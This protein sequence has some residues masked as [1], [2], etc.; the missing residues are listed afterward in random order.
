[1]QR[2]QYS[3]FGAPRRVHGGEASVGREKKTRPLST[4]RP[5]HIVFKS[6]RAKESLSF[7]RPE[8]RRL[9][10]SVIDRAKRRCGMK[11]YRTSINGN[12]I[13]LVAKGE[14]RCGIQNFLR[15]VAGQIAQR[16]GGAKKG[17]PAREAFWDYPVFTRI[18]EWGKD[19]TGVIRYVLMNEL[20]TLGLIP[21]KERVHKKGRPK[22]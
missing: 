5:L 12:H 14:T 2:A 20:E 7:C 9:V 13:H 8:N 11:L 16:I 18:L 15:T 19:F 1:M 21:Y 17:A 4:K 22:S 10:R 3:F 6:S